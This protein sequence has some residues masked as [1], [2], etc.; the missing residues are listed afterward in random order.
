MAALTTMATAAAGSAM[1][2]ASAPTPADRGGRPAAASAF[3]QAFDQARGASH[4]GGD[5]VTTQEAD[6]AQRAR[7]RSEDERHGAG[8]APPHGAPAT[9]HDEAGVTRPAARE[10]ADGGHGQTPMGV[11]AGPDREPGADAAARSGHSPGAG[12]GSGAAARAGAHDGTAAGTRAAAR[13]DQITDAASAALQEADPR[14]GNP[15]RSVDADAA[16]DPSRLIGLLL[17]PRAATPTPT[18]GLTAATAP[19]DAA[20]SGTH[21]AARQ[22]ALDARCG[23]ATSGR[24]ADSSLAA[25]DP[26]GG[27][28]AAAAGGF[29]AEL[30]ATREHAARSGSPQAPDEATSPLPA[31]AHALLAAPSG[32]SGIPAPTQARL[33]VGPGHPDFERQLGAQLTTFVRQG[34]EFARIELHPA[35]LGP[36]TLQIQ[37]DGQRAQV[38]FAAERVETRQALDAALPTLAGSLRDAGLTLAGGGVFQQ[39]RDSAAHDGGTTRRPN[40]EGAAAAE[41]ASP[42]AAAAAAVAVTRRRGVVDL[43]A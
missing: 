29:A 34:V 35:E 17:D 36:L 26:R 22:L 10:G 30:A 40:A 31:A 27:M 6:A 7:Q 20:R 1:S 37:L 21:R 15:A 5:A 39:P 2:P 4:G 43:V 23:R 18:D 38:H 3:M 24:A 32:A 41:A 8:A 28:P 33:A 9:S 19:A 12:C 14:T 13:G 16:A 11:A 42:I 25:D